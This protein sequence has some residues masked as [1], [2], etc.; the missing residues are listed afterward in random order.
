[1]KKGMNKQLFIPIAVTIGL[2]LFLAILPNRF[3][4][5]TFPGQERVKVEVI[6]VDNSQM[7]NAGM[8][9]YG[10]QLC[11]VKILQGSFKGQEGDGVNLL[12][13][14]L[15][16]DKVFVSGDKALAVIDTKEGK[17][18]FINLVDH[19]RIHK[20]IVLVGLFI[21]VLIAF[22]GAIGLRSILSFILTIMLIWKV[23]IPGFLMG[24]DPVWIGV[25][26]TMLLTMMIIL[27]VYGNDRRSWGAILGSFSGTL[28]TCVMAI[29]FVGDFKIHGAIMSHS[30]S[31]LYSGF[32]H[33]NLTRIFTASIFI[34]SS[35]AMMDV[36]VDITSAIA[37]LME[38]NPNLSK[39]EAILSG[40][41]VGRAVMGTMTTTLLL[42]YSGGYM[43]L[44]MVFMAQGTPMIN[45]LNL[46]YVASEI[47]HTI[48]GSF[49]L[50]TVAPFTALTAGLLLGA[51]KEAILIS[52]PEIH[53]GQ[54]IQNA[55]GIEDI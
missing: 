28:L 44:L 12:S 10:E 48:I 26:A 30:E 40:L 16:E 34:A 7:D 19:Y 20:E 27:L 53:E 11:R 39:K 17:I 50:V 46:K 43:A 35:G 31:L 14:K 2:I 22:A 1:M 4:A 15:E 18:S 37:E 33:L 32:S 41:N 45:I 23:V 9:L 13:G 36:A 5:I 8:S 54:G 24:I 51:K 29:Y 49:G 38:K 3:Q 21:V 42:A 52:D 25:G 55:Q 6:G 47:L